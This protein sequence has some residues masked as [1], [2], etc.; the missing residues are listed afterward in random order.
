MAEQTLTFLKGQLA[1]TP[2]QESAWKGYAEAALTLTNQH[3][4]TGAMTQGQP[5]SALAMA[6]TRTRFATQM[7]EQR[8]LTL[9]AFK[10]LWALLT[11]EQKAKTNH[12]FGR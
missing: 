8:N 12:F 10:S 11:D 4:G 2:E 7:V 5:D 1:I 6:E 3:G 9:T